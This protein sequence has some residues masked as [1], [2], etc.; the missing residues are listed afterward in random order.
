MASNAAIALYLCATL[1]AINNFV[2]INATTGLVLSHI[3]RVPSGQL[4]DKA[5]SL[6]FADQCV[7]LVCVYLWGVCSDVIGRRAVYASGFSIMALALALYPRAQSL[8]ALLLLRMLFAIGGAAAAS[9]LTAVLADYA[10]DSSR[11]SM[12]G[13]VGL[14]SGCGALLALLVFMPVPFRY[15]DLVEGIQT[16]YLAVAAISAVLAVL[17]ALFLLPVDPEQ[18]VPPTPL[19]DGESLLE[20][21]SR[22]TSF[23][24]SRPS[25]RLLD[26]SGST[27]P[28]PRVVFVQSSESK[29]S[30]LNLAIEGFT[31]AKD[32]KVLLGYIGSFLARGDTVIITLFIPLWVYK[33]YIEMGDCSAPS[34]DDP[35]IRDMCRAAFR[36]ASAISGIAQTAALIGAPVFGYLSDRFHPSRVVLFNAVLGFISYLIMFY[37]DPVKGYVFGLVIFVGLSEIGLVIGNISLV[38]H[39]GSVKE[40]VRGSVAGVS[41]ACGAL[42]ILIAS[43]LGG[44]L[45]D[46]WREGAPFLVLAVGHFVA[47]VCGVYVVSMGVL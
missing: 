20:S 9:M 37:A 19:D 36:R 10:R 24:D 18:P 13:L 14:F 16:T 4:G 31:A 6:S 3:Q 1:V 34:P 8:A 35:D 25:S 44:Y 47:I 28:P 39:S 17:L 40:S 43:K 21:M 32:P 42:G 46:N 45:F 26:H 12:A 7:S 33:R 27:I 30:I 5:G 15:A 38:T 29:T 2:F 22:E 41:S 11:G 23:E